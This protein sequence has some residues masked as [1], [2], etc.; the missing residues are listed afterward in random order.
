LAVYAE[1]LERKEA[2]TKAKLHWSRGE[3]FIVEVPN[4]P[5]SHT[6][7]EFCRLMI[8]KGLDKPYLQGTGDNSKWRSAA[9][10]E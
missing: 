2:V 1:V 8:V 5:H 7:A 4:G 3:V 9:R 10:S 6:T